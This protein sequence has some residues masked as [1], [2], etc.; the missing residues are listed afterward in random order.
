MRSKVFISVIVVVLFVFVVIFTTS[1][2]DKVATFESQKVMTSRAIDVARD[3]KT[4]QFTIDYDE[5]S[6]YLNYDS[7]PDRR[8]QAEEKYSK[9]VTE[10]HMTKI[11]MTALDI[12]APNLAQDSKSHLSVKDISFE[13]GNMETESEVSLDY[14]I[15]IE[16]ERINQEGKKEI[17]SNFGQIRVIK[18]DDGWKVNK[19]IQRMDGLHEV[20]KQFN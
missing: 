9:Y 1:E 5:S 13:I 19:D 10:S 6:D 4:E 3:F 20:R 12:I 7:L 8:K 15:E 11:L 16:F 2:E 18:T 17:I 14:D